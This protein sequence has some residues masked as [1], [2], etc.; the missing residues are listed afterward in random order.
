MKKADLADNLL[1][2]RKDGFAAADVIGLGANGD[3]GGSSRWYKSPMYHVCIYLSPI[4]R[5]RTQLNCKGNL[6]LGEGKG[7]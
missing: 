7:K 4:L 2:A 5:P 3:R 6:N 1:L